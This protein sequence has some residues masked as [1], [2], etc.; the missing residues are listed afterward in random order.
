MSTI[1]F[2]DIRNPKYASPD[3]S[4][5]DCEV[6]F[7]HLGRRGAGG[8]WEPEWVPFT[9]SLHDCEAHGVAIFTSLA[10]GEWGEVAVF[11]PR[12]APAPKSP[13][14]RL[15]ERFSAEELAELKKLVK[16]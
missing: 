1:S 9:A 5:I 8:V 6:V 10:K 4:K 13:R 7:S 14:E 16:E 15:L 3:G 11:V 2:A 12:P